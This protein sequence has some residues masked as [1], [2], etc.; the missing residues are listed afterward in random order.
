MATKQQKASRHPMRGPIQPA[1]A[2]QNKLFF[3]S[4]RNSRC[5]H[6]STLA[7]FV[8]VFR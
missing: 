7:I 2:D 4:E 8:S 1:P 5:D 3:I 6:D